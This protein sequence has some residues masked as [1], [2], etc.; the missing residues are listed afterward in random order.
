M[1]DEK[2]SVVLELTPAG[3]QRAYILYEEG[4]VD[5]LERGNL[6][7]ARISPQLLLIDNALRVGRA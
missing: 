3:L 5:S 4:D 1:D 2:L 6:L 7:L